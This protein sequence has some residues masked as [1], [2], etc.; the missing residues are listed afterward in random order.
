[1]K[2]AILYLT[3]FSCILSLPAWS[4]A[5]A[6][7]PTRLSVGARILGMGKTF[8][9]L[10]DDIGAI[11][12][13][14]AGLANL[15]K[16]QLS[17]MSGKFMEDYNYL[18]FSGAYPTKYGVLGFGYALSSIAGGYA[19]KIKTG[20]SADPVYEIDP[21][22]P[23]ISYDNNV[24]V[25]SYGNK[26]PLSFLSSIET[27]AGANLK[28][29]SAK[30]AGDGITSGGANGQ[31]LDIGCLFKI[32][33]WFSF[34]STLQDALPFSMGGK[35]SYASGHEESYP[36]TWRNGIALKILGE[37]DALRVYGLQELKFLFDVDSYP[38][39]KNF[40]LICHTGIEWSPVKMV[41]V[42]AGI[43]QDASGDGNGTG[44]SAI[45][46]MT[47]GVGV[48]FEGFSFDYA[49]HQ[50]AN[51]PGITNNY[52]SLS[53]TPIPK[54]SKVAAPAPAPLPSPPPVITISEK[55]KPAPVTIKKVKPASK[56]TKPAAK[57]RRK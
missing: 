6:P 11:Y 33:P 4:Q 8:I 47:A 53:Y 23:T 49:Y 45:S 25:F 50:Y 37:K 55:S 41:A 40:P 44:L 38:T 34:G 7:D 31:E 2:R 20:T 3:L 35:L 28:L 14:P 46:N 56:K 15:D 16:W 17:S 9:G 54:P 36:S 32:K 26:I 30:M 27:S 1:M 12:T 24:M 52:F 21:S 5:V 29:F 42:R 43:D 39:R 57:K 13:N 48:N 19:T 10:S 18:N 22:Q 51:V